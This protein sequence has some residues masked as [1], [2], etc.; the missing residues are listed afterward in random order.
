MS[1][2][3]A[4]ARRGMKARLDIDQEIVTFDTQIDQ[5]VL[6][7]VSRLSPTVYK[8]VTRQAVTVV[9][10]SYGETTVDLSQLEDDIDDI[11]RVEISAGGTEY[12]ADSY[13]IHG[14]ELFVRE[15]PTSTTTLY[16]YGL[17]EFELVD[18]P[19]YLKL[20]VYYFA[21]SEFYTF[22]IANKAKYSVY[23]QNG[24][25]AVESMQDL[26][27]FFETKGEEFLTKKAQPYAG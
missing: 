19:N 13:T 3:Q 2:T 9:V 11:R 20:A 10:S 25:G 8:Q 7:A 24:R 16:I 4:E 21:Q 15:V 27:D 14:T 26:A 5:F 1:M 6:D 12:Q 17:K 18:V 22:L 23:M